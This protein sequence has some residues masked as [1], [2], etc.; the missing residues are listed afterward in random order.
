MSKELS[1]LRVRQRRTAILLGLPRHVSW[2]AIIE[3]PARWSGS[4]WMHF[5]EGP[6]LRLTDDL[7]IEDTTVTV[8]RDLTV[9]D[10][11]MPADKASDYVRIVGALLV[12][13]VIHHL[14]PS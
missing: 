4:G 2:R 10:W 5:L 11:S 3:M 6:G 8:L 14:I 9:G 1:R 12:T 13:L 7:R